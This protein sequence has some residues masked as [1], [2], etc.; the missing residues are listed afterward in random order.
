MTS[1]NNGCVKSGA[2]ATITGTCSSDIRCKKNIAPIQDMLDRITKLEVVN[3]DLRANEFPEEGW[4]SERQ[5][6]FIAQQVEAVMPELV[7]T[8]A[9]GYK[10]SRFKSLFEPKNSGAILL[11]ILNTMLPC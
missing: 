7:E 6:G 11:L 10:A 1:T 2:N 9:K 4:G 5:L 3:Y 8:D